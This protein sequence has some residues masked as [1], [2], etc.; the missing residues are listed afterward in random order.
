MDIISRKDAN[1]LNLLYYFTGNPCVRGHVAKRLTRNATCCECRLER[2]RNYKRDNRAHYRAVTK[3]YLRANPQIAMLENARHRARTKGWEFSI[4]TA[5]IH[6]PEVCPVLGI[7][8]FRG[9]GKSGPNSPSIDRIDSSKGY[10]PDNIHVI[11][12]RA[13]TIKND[14]TIDE[15][16][17]LIK[18]LKDLPS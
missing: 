2:D 9:N 5:D 8:L 17:A 16:E 11:S 3:A 6:I 4:T 10:T 7:P 14:A 12:H 18:Y 15:L 1:Q 13:N